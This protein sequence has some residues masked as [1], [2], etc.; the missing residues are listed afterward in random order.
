MLLAVIQFQPKVDMLSQTFR[1]IIYRNCYLHDVFNVPNKTASE[2]NTKKKRGK[3][4]ENT[5]TQ[6][7]NTAENRKKKTTKSFSPVCVCHINTT[8]S[9]CSYLHG[10]TLK[11]REIL[12]C[13][14]QS[15]KLIHVK[16]I[17]QTI[18]LQFAA[19]SFYQFHI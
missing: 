12:W 15:Q 2:T 13:G 17:E 4:Y 14:V 16:D 6:Y 10:S 18:L 3:L 8:H 5:R 9:Q 7:A 1:S 11:I 19:S